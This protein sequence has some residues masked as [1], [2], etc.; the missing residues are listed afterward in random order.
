MGNNGLTIT[1]I[2]VIMTSII[3]YQAFSNMAMKQKLIF[4]PVSIKE[5]GE[6]YR[7][8]TSGFLHGDFGHLLINMYVLYIFGEYVELSFM[9]PDIFGP[10]MGRILFV[11]LY[12]GAVVVSSIPTYFKHQ[13]NNYYMALG[14]SGGTSAM[15]FAFIIFNPW[16]WFLFPPLPGILMAV[17]FLFY[18]SYM[19]KKGADNI[20]HNAHFTGAIYGFVFVMVMFA[21]MAPDQLSLFTRRLLAGPTMPNFF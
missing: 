12:F 6:Y 1:L 18:S 5:R 13:N 20:G 9:R 10:T 8:L 21:L 14:A 3:S 2:I 19:D 7:F 16:G 11:L 4:H 17:G 15:V